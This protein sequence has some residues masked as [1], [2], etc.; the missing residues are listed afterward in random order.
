MRVPRYIYYSKVR[1]LG[2]PRHRGIYTFKIWWKCESKSTTWVYIMIQTLLGAYKSN[3]FS[4]YYFV[5]LLN[6]IL[7]TCQSKFEIHDITRQF[8]YILNSTTL[9][10]FCF[11]NNMYVTKII[12]AT[13]QW[14]GS[15]IYCDTSMYHMK[16][17]FRNA[18]F[19]FLHFL[20]V[21]LFTL[22]YT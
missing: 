22:L 16:I 14:D 3:Q 7:L 4:H 12:F 18:E 20:P 17:I 8:H 9:K 1:K 5:S 21:S 6:V 19:F 10:R 2:K 15:D 11:R 13:L